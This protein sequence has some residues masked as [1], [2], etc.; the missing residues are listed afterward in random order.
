MA[1]VNTGVPPVATVYQLNE[2]LG[3]VLLAV[4]VAALAEQTVEPPCAVTVGAYG[5]SLII[6]L[7]VV[8]GDAQ[9]APFT[10]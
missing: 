5:T 4:K 3:S 1:P 10:A 8:D 2:T 9:P 6:T 7:T